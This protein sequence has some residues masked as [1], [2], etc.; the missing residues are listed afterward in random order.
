MLCKYTNRIFIKIRLL[1]FSKTLH[2]Q[3]CI[4]Q[5]IL[6]PYRAPWYVIS[7]C[8]YRL[9]SPVNTFFLYSKASF[10]L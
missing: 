2:K 6:Y 5:K 3:T 1:V 4:F 9:I 8:I 10:Y 7:R